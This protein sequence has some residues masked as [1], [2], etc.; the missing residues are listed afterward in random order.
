MIEKT[1]E[2]L[3]VVYTSNDEECLAKI[4]KLIILKNL[5][6]NNNI[7][8]MIAKC[9]LQMDSIDV[10][11]IINGDIGNIK[12][13][14]FLR[15]LKVQNLEIGIG[16]SDTQFFNDLKKNLDTKQE[17]IVPEKTDKCFDTCQKS[18]ES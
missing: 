6:V 7:N 15:L 5:T 3:V 12:L 13:N 9:N 2:N 1:I 17:S 14:D 16:M 8:D 10:I 11:D 18:M 4:L